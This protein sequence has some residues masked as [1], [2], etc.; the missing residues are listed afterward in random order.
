M[1]ISLPIKLFL[2]G[3]AIIVSLAGT[4]EA[5]WSTTHT[6][7]ETVGPHTPESGILLWLTPQMLVG[8]GANNAAD[9]P[10]PH[11]RRA[12]EMHL[13]IVNGCITTD[14]YSGPVDPAGIQKALQGAEHHEAGYGWNGA[15]GRSGGY[16]AVRQ[17]LANDAGLGTY[18]RYMQY[19]KDYCYYYEGGTSSGKSGPDT[20]RYDPR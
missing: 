3:L 9:W 19:S 12:C 1:T 6:P 4:A 13:A 11:E 5:D 15:W 7:G 8:H 14:P 20:W 17:C 16:S 2:G 18:I 10:G